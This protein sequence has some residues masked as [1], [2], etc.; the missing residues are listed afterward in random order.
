MDDAERNSLERKVG[1]LLDQRNLREAAGE[2]IRGYGPEIAA[3]LRAILREPSEADEVFSR[4]CEKVWRGL[5]RFRRASSVRTWL[6]AIANNAARDFKQEDAGGRTR[7]LRTGEHSQLAAAV[8]SSLPAYAKGSAADALARLRQSLEPEEQSLLTLRL[9]AGLSWKQVAEVLSAAG[10]PLDQ[11]AV[12][13]RF[14]RLKL[15]LREVAAA[16]GLLGN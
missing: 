6:Y 1:E 4:F 16:A 2:A 3:Y 15:K 13:K 5:P 12:R 7:R 10:R 11:A 14:E 8:L 9:Y